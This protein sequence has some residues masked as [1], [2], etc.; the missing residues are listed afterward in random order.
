MGFGTIF[1]MREDDEDAIKFAQKDVHQFG[2]EEKSIN[3]DLKL[4]QTK[5]KN[6]VT[7]NH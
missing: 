3:L 5:P 2:F 1:S 6:Q 4:T 7:Q